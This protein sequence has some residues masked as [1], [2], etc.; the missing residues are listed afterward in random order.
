MFI[1]CAY[2]SD[3]SI[4]S[5]PTEEDYRNKTAGLNLLTQTTKPVKIRTT[6]LELKGKAWNK[7]KLNFLILKIFNKYYAKKNLPAKEEKE[8]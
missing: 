2:A 8:S 5:L 4:K 7:K 1:K 3:K 6:Y